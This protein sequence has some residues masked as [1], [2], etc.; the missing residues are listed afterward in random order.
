MEHFIICLNKLY[1]SFLQEYMLQDILW[2][3]FDVLCLAIQSILHIFFIC[4]LTEKAVRFSYFAIYFQF[5]AF[6]NTLLVKPLL[7]QRLLLLDNCL[8][9]A[10]SAASS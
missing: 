5:Y 7:S 8:F 2:L 1:I 10:E 4:R 6:S 3:C 9:Y